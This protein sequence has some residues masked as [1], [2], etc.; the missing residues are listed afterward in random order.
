MGAFTLPRELT[1]SEDGTLRIEPAEE[2][3]AM[4]G[5][6]QRVN[7]LSI[8]A[9]TEVP[10]LEIHGDALELIAVFNTNQSA[11]DAEFGLASSLFRG[12]FRVYGSELFGLTGS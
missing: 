12:W 3:K 8:Y 11:G 5:T 9:G 10:L 6:H 1:L 2:L 4:R 7:N